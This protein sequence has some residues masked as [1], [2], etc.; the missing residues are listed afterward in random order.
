MRYILL[1][2]LLTACRTEKPKV[3]YMIFI[4]DTLISCKKEIVSPYGSLLSSCEVALTE[5]KITDIQQATNYFEVPI[6]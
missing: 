3:Q 6:E 4:N 2:L 1:L 5:Q